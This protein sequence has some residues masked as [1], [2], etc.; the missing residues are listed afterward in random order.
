MNKQLQQLIE[1]HQKFE[2]PYRTEPDPFDDSEEQKKTILLRKR[3]MIEEVNEWYESAQFNDDIDKRAK[4]L[5]DI[6]Y[7]VF[8]TIITEGL[9]DGIERVFDEVHKSNMSKLDENGKP[10]KRADGKVLKSKLYKEPDLSFL[11]NNVQDVQG[12][13]TTNDASSNADGNINS[14]KKELPEYVYVETS[15]LEK[16]EKNGWYYVINSQ[17]GDETHEK[18]SLYFNDGKWYNYHQL[19]FSHWLK[20]VNT[21]ELIKNNRQ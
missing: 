3:I 4:E 7:I 8:S 15:A 16:P 1:W 17:G 14:H 2:V 12:S 11:L 21:L 19:N 20:K 9:Q 5:A 6:L 10:V 13:D 18:Y